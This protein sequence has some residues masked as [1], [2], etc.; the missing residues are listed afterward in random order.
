MFARITTYKMH[1]EKIAEAETTLADLL[2]QIMSMNGLKSFTNV[3]DEEGNGVI[4]S[5]VESKELSDANQEQVA[6]I[7]SAFSDFLS[8]PPSMKGYRVLAHAQN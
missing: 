1:P 6:K 2:P 5:V 3:I 8:E 7:W 4:C